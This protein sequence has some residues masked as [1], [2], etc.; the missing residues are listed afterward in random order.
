MNYIDKNESIFLHEM[1]VKVVRPIV[2]RIAN[3]NL[4][5]IT[6]GNG[7][8]LK[9]LVMSDLVKQGVFTSMDEAEKHKD[10]IYTAITM[11]LYEYLPATALKNSWCDQF[12]I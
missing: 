5:F 1:D 9:V 7:Y 11:S 3:N 4:S 12:M 6:D 8:T 10:E 2:K